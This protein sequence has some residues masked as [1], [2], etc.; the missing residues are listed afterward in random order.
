MQALTNWATSPAQKIFMKRLKNRQAE[1]NKLPNKIRSK[2][3][4]KHYL[5]NFAL[6]S[7]QSNGVSLWHFP[8]YILLYFDCTFTPLASS[9]PWPPSSKLTPWL[10][11]PSIPWPS[12][13]PTSHLLLSWHINMYLHTWTHLSINFSSNNKQDV[14]LIWFISLSIMISGSINFPILL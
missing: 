5:I 14:F 13:L 3:D 8:M 1:V 9:Q 10:S 7:T 6:V 4:L 11:C 12:C 2:Y